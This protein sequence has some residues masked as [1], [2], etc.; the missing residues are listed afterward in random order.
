MTAAAFLFLADAGGFLGASGGV[1]S[2]GGGAFGEDAVP[3]AGPVDAAKF[4]ACR[5]DDLVTLGDVSGCSV[6]RLGMA[7][8]KCAT[9][10][11]CCNHYAGS[12]PLKSQAG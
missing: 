4:A 5:A 11:G 2:V 3:E 8:K 7:K 10:C 1:S 9:I 12:S 6:F